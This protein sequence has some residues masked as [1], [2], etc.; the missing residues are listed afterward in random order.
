MFNIIVKKN[1]QET[2]YS[3]AN[4][5]DFNNLNQG[6][7]PI[8][9]LYIVFNLLESRKISIDDIVEI[10]DIALKEKGKGVVGYQRTDKINLLQV[11]SNFKVTAG[12]D[13]LFLLANHVYIK[14][15][16]KMSEYFNDLISQYGLSPDCALN[17]SG[18]P[19]SKLKQVYSLKDIEVIAIL[20]A[21]INPFYKNVLSLSKIFYKGKNFIANTYLLDLNKITYFFS[22]LNVSIAWHQ[23]GINT[24]TIII[25]QGIDQVF[26]QDSVIERILLNQPINLDTIANNKVNTELNKPNVV[27][28]IIG[29]TYLGEYYTERRRKRKN[30]FDPLIHGGYD[31][32]FEKIKDFLKDA[33]INLANHE[34][35]FIDDNIQSPLK[36]LKKFILGAKDQPTVDA[37]KKANIHYLSLANNHIAD[38]GDLGVWHS[39]KT[40]KQ[41]GIH[42]CGAGMN[43]VDACKPIRIKI[44]G[45]V[46][47]LYS[48]YWH[49]ATNQKIFKF[50]ATPSQPGV[51]TLESMLSEAIQYEKKHYPEHMVIVLAHWGV[52]FLPTQHYQRNI[53]KQLFNYGADLIVGHGAHTLQSIEQFENKVVLFSIGNGIFNSDGEYDGYPN[54]LP[55][56]IIAQL[57]FEKDK[58]ALRLLPILSNNR[59]SMWQPDFVQIEE[60]K[61]VQEFYANNEFDYI[62][63]T[64]WP[65]FFEK[66]LI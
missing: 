26:Q 19:N 24:F 58:M 39:L 43:E 8:F 64:K 6:L 15:Q 10:N 13:S 62:N 63:S 17:L 18:K 36:G 38:Y 11:L 20:L 59:K 52:D 1:E 14:T 7:G 40:L 66:N 37:L 4:N 29:D 23:T 21:R 16:K 56:G 41:A 33:D 27:V 12:V 35:C 45:R 2:D 60:F 57:I 47:S 31:Y 5:I 44:N 51:A 28:N 49:R 22:F 34:A 46:I 3:Y 61:A 32:S 9:V 65:Y 55:F 50:Y 25:S 48:G 42:A 54:A 30:F 53:A